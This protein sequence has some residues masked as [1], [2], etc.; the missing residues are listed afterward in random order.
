MSVSQWKQI[1]LSNSGNIL[2][3]FTVMG[4]DIAIWCTA[5]V[6]LDLHI[7]NDWID[8]EHCVNIH[9]LY[10]RYTGDRMLHGDKGEMKVTQ[11]A[12]F[13]L[14]LSVG[15]AIFRFLPLSL[16]GTTLQWSRHRWPLFP[17]PGPS[18]WVGTDRERR[19]DLKEF[20]HSSVSPHI[21]VWECLGSTLPDRGALAPVRC[22]PHTI[23]IPLPLDLD[24]L[25][26][27]P[28]RQSGVKG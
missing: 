20:T 2:Q 9:L 12:F 8:H 24:S 15:L 28:S 19:G 23:P 13:A 10:V 25:S 5:G 3:L 1:C 7:G 21:D 4:I 6:S 11:I 18:R 14:C 17:P 26:P 27:W 22:S 16:G